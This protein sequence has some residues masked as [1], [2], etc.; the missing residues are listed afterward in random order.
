MKEVKRIILFFPQS[1]EGDII[2][3]PASVLMVAAPLV[4]AGYEIKIIDQR[5]DRDWKD[6]LLEELKNSPLIFGVSA[7]TGKQILNGLEASI[8]V[9]QNSKVPVV[10]GGVHVSLLPHQV[11]ESKFIDFAVIGEG[12]ETFME[13]IEALEAGA[14]PRKIMGLGYKSEGKII[15][16]SQRE[17]INLNKIVDVPYRLIDVER[18]ISKKSFSTG[19][20]ARNI[21]LYTSRGCPHRCGFCYNKEFNKRKWR[22]KS[23]E[24]VFREIKALVEKYNITAFEIE[25]DE[26]FV[27]IER[28][29]KISELI[30][31]N[32]LNIEIFTSCRVNYVVNM[33]ANYLDLIYR[34]GFKTLAFGVES[35]SERILRLM[36][37]D[38]TIEQVFE[39]IKKLKKAG[40]NS[41]YYFM[42]GFPTETI[43]DLYETA[44]LIKKMKELDPQ[45]R[46]P[47]WRVFTP[48]PGTDLYGLAIKEGWQ[49]PKTLEEWA[50]YNF[51][52][53]KMPWVK[54]REKRIIKNVA[55]LVDYLEMRKTKG[56]GLFFELAKIFSKTVDYRWE[57]HLFSFV[58]ERHVIELLL[59]LKRT[60]FF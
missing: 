55:F 42:A 1:E 40:I 13:L 22:G 45:I 8:L 52:T 30:I 20:P 36:N 60:R 29:R 48:Y 17:F 47:S 39:T 12:E 16:N 46:I 21:A 54:G 33:D 27:D 35:G 59:K 2:L 25:D 9:K 4:V 41:K 37:K 51:K 19:N 15:L 32:N 34:A 18:Y 44:D 31:V 7:L 53:I 50:N 49:P 28:A 58:P 23:A 10:W 14:D 38:I 26:F 5:V 57:K 6:S 24:N 43:N 3:L 11:L 56:R